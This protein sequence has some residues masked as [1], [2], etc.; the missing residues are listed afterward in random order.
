MN[1]NLNDPGDE[2][3]ESAFSAMRG[4]PVPDGP[5]E[6]QITETISALSAAAQLK[7]NIFSRMNNMRFITGM[8]ASVLLVVGSVVAAIMMLRSPAVTCAEVVETVR[9]ARYMSC[10]ITTRTAGTQPGRMK[11]LMNDQGQMQMRGEGIANV[12]IVVDTRT[13]RNMTL[14]PKMK[15]AVIMDMKNLPKKSNSPGDLID[16]FKK[17]QGDSAKDLGKTEIDG[18]KAEKFVA[19]QEGQEYTIWADPQSREPIRVDISVNMLD[20]KITA[21]MTDFDFNPTV[22]DDAFSMEIPKGYTVEKFSLDLPDINNGEQNVVRGYAQRSDGK[23]PNKLEDM[24]PYIALFEKHA[25]TR[26]SQ[27]DEAFI[28]LLVRFQFVKH[29][30]VTLPKGQWSYEGDGKT[31]G[32]S[33]SLIFWYKSAKGYRGIFGD[34]TVRDLSAA[35]Q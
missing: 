35:P 15:I 19:T 14:D 21:S 4:R 5:P 18:R 12:R 7:P 30:L 8:A 25:T 20:Q 33:R 23:F 2:I 27:P 1:E 6:R 28:Q 29:F 16:G 34:L 11:I 26:S 13:G 10:L 32:D 3:L 31:T 17:L 24:S 9:S 22:P